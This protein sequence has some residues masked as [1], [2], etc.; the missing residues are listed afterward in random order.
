MSPPFRFPFSVSTV[1]SVPF[2]RDLSSGFPPPIFGGAEPKRLPTQLLAP[3]I[4]LNHETPGKRWKSVSAVWTV[5]RYSSAK[6]PS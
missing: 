5:P 4:G 3:V 2:A 1:P 6:A